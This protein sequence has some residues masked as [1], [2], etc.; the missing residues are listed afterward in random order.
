MFSIII[1]I[2]LEPWL[3]VLYSLHFSVSLFFWNQYHNTLLKVVL[4]RCIS[5]RI[6][7]SISYVQKLCYFQVFQSHHQIL[8]IQDVISLIFIIYLIFFS[9][10]VFEYFV[11]V[12]YFFARLLLVHHRF[13]LYQNFYIVFFL[14]KNTL[15]SKSSDVKSFLTTFRNS[16]AV[17]Y[18][19][20][21][22]LNCFVFLRTTFRICL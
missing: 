4:L 17:L 15:I 9:N 22:S 8:H 7:F 16:S 3:S 12:H 18:C 5:L 6:L 13:C 2:I 14:S 10:T 1:V 19:Y 20:N 11:S 21:F